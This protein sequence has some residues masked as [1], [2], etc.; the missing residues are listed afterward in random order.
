MPVGYS[1]GK[2]DAQFWSDQLT[3][4]KEFRKQYTFE[5]DWPRWR[6]YYRG[7]YRQSVVQPVN[8]F[9]M[10]IR[11]VVPR[12]YFRNP[13]VSV[14]PAMPGFLNMAFAQVLNRIDNKMLLTMG[15]K[16]A[17]KM[18][19]QDAFTFG[20]G[21]GKLG[22]GSVFNLSGADDEAPLDKD[23]HKVEYDPK[24]QPFIPWF[25]RIPTGNFYIQ[26]GARE[27][28]EA[29][30]FFHEV[31]RTPD[32]IKADPRFK[33]RGLTLHPDTNLNI[34][35]WPADK[36]GLITLYEIH[37]RKTDKVIVMG[38]HLNDKNESGKIIYEERSDWDKPPFFPVIFNPD[39]EV[40]WGVPD[41]HILEPHQLEL[42][43]I[44]TQ[45]M[46][47]RRLSIIKLIATEN[48]ISEEEA[49]KM[50]SEDVN[51]VV[52]V[53]G[54]NIAGS[55][56]RFQ[57]SDIPAALPLAAQQVMEIIRE[58]M[59]F[60]RNQAGE[61]MGGSE[62]PTAE[63]V[64]TVRAANDIRV[65]ERRDAVAD[66]IVDMVTMMN[67][68]LFRRWDE[69]QV[70][71]VV[72]PGGATVWVKVNPRN[73]R[74]GRYQVRV[75]PDSSVPLTQQERESR[76]AN[77]YQLFKD[78]PLIDPM[79]LTHMLISELNGVQLDDLMRSLPAAQGQ[80]TGPMEL[81]QFASLI[82]NQM[83]AA[84]A[85]QRPQQVPANAGQQ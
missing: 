68:M 10:M 25:A 83:G 6:D 38:P 70:V 22:F 23:G 34:A 2:A 53:K 74:M 3:L 9:F 60:S 61:Y 8:V 62:K 73:L 66:M 13:T 54:R 20:T 19:V 76:A 65:D 49:A 48:S 12:I 37:D 58:T 69:Q 14:S 75:D 57:V 63:E 43:E 15:A 67:E 18:I 28:D 85:G 7:R 39:D 79:K 52:R 17:N 33:T 72:G 51:A 59:G 27:F 35:G 81:D 32:D 29:R 40:F 36:M 47:H 84:Q 11:S 4:A 41:S 77:I 82:G 71:D 64:A 26:A 45:I 42:N 55:I 31:K 80:P 5:M 1:G 16:K 46:K 21:I 56:D 24:V 30:F 78:N 50:I 44:N